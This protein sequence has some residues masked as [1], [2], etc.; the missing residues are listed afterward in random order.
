MIFNL[1]ILRITHWKSFYASAIVLLRKFGKLLQMTVLQ[2]APE[3][4]IRF[5]Y[6]V[7][8][9]SQTKLNV[10]WKIWC[11]FVM[12]Q[13]FFFSCIEMCCLLVDDA[14]HNCKRTG[15]TVLEDRK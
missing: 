9:H 12:G 4:L 6:F 15:G 7:L 11:G 13:F 10:L 14:I 5:K 3:T 2:F 8:C 1:N